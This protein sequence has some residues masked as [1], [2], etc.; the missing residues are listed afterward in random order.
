MQ[1][2]KIFL[3]TGLI[4][5][6]GIF[7]VLLSGRQPEIQEK[8]VESASEVLNAEKI[9]VIH[10]HSTQQCWACITVGELALK[11]IEQEFPEE[12]DQGVITFRD[13][14]VDLAE[15]KELASK[16]KAR[17]SSV[18]VNAIVQGE[19]NIEEDVAVWRLIR[20]E[21]KYIEYFAE[22][23]NDLLGK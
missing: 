11:T 3:I 1:T 12:Y 4:L 7:F 14:N 2:N 16:F 19:D 22:K 20:N 15:N 10:F 21:E 9:E 8:K 6:V 23:L 13:V 17:G 5:I 18:F